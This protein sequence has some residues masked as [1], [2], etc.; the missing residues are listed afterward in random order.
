M[1]KTKSNLTKVRVKEIFMV[2]L[3]VVTLMLIISFI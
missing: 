2:I 3:L 1:S